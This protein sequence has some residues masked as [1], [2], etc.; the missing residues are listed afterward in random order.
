MVFGVWAFASLPRT[1]KLPRGFG[2]AGNLLAELYIPYV[3]YNGGYNS[4]KSVKTTG[5]LTVGSSGTTVSQ[6][7]TGS[8]ALTGMN[9]S[10]TATTTSPYDCAVT[11]VVAGDF[12]VA[13]L[14]TTTAVANLTHQA[15]NAGWVVMGAEASSTNGY[16]TVS[17][18]NFT[19][20]ARAPASSPGLG[21]TT[22]YIIFR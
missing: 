20:T 16:I 17:I 15:A 10:Q 14:A 11:G 4:A 5:D 12:V 8:C 1:A 19:G 7:I 9:V 22:N 21:S 6:I 18:G 13:Q 3:Q 2:A